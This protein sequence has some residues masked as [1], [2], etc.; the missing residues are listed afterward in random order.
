ML[1]RRSQP[2]PLCL[3][4]GLQSGC[5]LSREVPGDPL[6]LCSTMCITYRRVVRVSTNK[7][8]NGAPGWLG[9]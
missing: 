9:R 5:R 1:C 7:Q 6:C 8:G 4:M 2:S 3:M